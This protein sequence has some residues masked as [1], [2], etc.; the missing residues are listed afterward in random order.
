MNIV[1]VEKEN[2]KD[3]D[4][5]IDEVEISYYQEPDCESSKDSDY[6]VLRLKTA[7]N[8]V[9][10][11]IFMETSRWAFDEIDDIIK[12]LEDFKKRAF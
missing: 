5:F 11:F 10:R 8:G 9:G 3:E 1:N 7:N 2:K 6:Q 12:I 4:V